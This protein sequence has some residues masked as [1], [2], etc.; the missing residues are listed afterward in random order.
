MRRKIDLAVN[1]PDEVDRHLD[2]SVD[3]FDV[4]RLTNV[5]LP[6]LPEKPGLVSAVA[7]D[8]RIPNRFERPQAALPYCALAI[9]SISPERVF[10][11]LVA[12]FKP[13]PDKVVKVPI[14]HPFNIK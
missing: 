1:A 4:A 3:E 12:A 8:L 7:D 2:E 5:T 13:K 14:R 11:H 6:H 9:R 10:H